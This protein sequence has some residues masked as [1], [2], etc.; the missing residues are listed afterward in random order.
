MYPHVI[1]TPNRPLG[2]GTRKGAVDDHSSPSRSFI[3][4]KGTDRCAQVIVNHE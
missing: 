3:E 1:R 2:K 4:A